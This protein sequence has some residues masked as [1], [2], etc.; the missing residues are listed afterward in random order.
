M[1]DV[2]SWV[3]LVGGGLISIVAGIGLLRFPDL[4][5]RM[6]AASMLDTL[7][8]GCVVLG[9]V[10]QTIVH[11]VEKGEDA[12]LT[13]FVAFKLILVF[14]FLAFTTSTAGHALAK[15]ALASGVRPRAADGSLLPI[16]GVLAND[17]S[18]VRGEEGTSSPR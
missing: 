3:L 10:F 5:T 4:Y 16:G 9:L 1:L 11:M 12:T 6:H 8:A 17:E 14:V 2:L 18:S 7:G 15:S 13:P